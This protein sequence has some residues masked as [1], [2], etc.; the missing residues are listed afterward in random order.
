MSIGTVSAPSG[1]VLV[2][3]EA[4]VGSSAIQVVVT[5]TVAAVKA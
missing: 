1:V 2:Y 4:T 3:T 5:V